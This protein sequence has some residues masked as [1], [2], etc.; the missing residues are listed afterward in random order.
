MTVNIKKLHWI[1]R[2][3]MLGILAVL[4][5]G[6]VP[7]DEYSYDPY[8]GYYDGGYYDGGYYDGGGVIVGGPGYYEPYGAEYRGWGSGYRVAPF[9]RDGFGPGGFNRGAPSTHHYRPAPASHSMPSLP[10]RSRPSAPRARR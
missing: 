3:F 10:S 5:V 2:A 4:A 9:H 7:L 6:C 1:C 8:G